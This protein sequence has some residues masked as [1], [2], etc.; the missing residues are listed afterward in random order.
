MKKIL[1]LA[2]VITIVF[3]TG[4]VDTNYYYNSFNSIVKGK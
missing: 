1:G 3:I 2:I 4:C